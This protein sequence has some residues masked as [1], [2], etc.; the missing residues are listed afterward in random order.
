MAPAPVAN[1]LIPPAPARR[2]SRN[3]NPTEHGHA[4]REQLANDAARCLTRI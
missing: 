1:A 2:S 4:Y 3:Q